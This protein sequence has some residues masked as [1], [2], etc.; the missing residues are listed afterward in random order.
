MDLTLEDAL[1]TPDINRPARDMVSFG[2]FGRAG[3]TIGIAQATQVSGG[4]FLEAEITGLAPGEYAM[5]IHET[6][7]CQ[8]PFDGAGGHFNPGG[9][10]HG[11]DNPRGAH[12][13]D[14]A[15]IQVPDTRFVTISAVAAGATLR[16][17]LDES[18]ADTDG[19]ALIIHDGRDDYRSDPGGNSGPRIAC[20][21]IFPP[22]E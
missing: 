22:V 21:V 15:N 9:T 7:Y 13:G 14:L 16:P 19:S 5:H 10:E 2:L 11:Q 4:I 3:E 12:V 17:G 20:G 1:G 18:L 8:A 6:G